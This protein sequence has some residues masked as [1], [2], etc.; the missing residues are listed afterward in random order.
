VACA[1]I[2]ASLAASIV[3]SSS[4]EG[5]EPAAEVPLRTYRTVSP[6]QH[7]PQD[8]AVGYGWVGLDGAGASDQ[9]IDSLVLGVG[10]AGVG[11]KATVKV[12]GVV[13]AMPAPPSGSTGTTTAGSTV[14]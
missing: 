5:C 11:V 10:I 6:Q 12:C 9:S 13:V 2:S 4:Y 14:R 7:R 8:P 3:T 1:A